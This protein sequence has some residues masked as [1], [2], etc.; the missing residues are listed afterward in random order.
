MFT[1]NLKSSHGPHIKRGWSTLLSAHRRLTVDLPEYEV[2]VLV[3]C[4][5]VVYTCF[6]SGV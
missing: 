4:F 5:P 1:D 2:E 3:W 6:T